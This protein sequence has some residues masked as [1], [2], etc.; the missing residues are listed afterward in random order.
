[1]LLMMSRKS[2]FIWLT[3]QKN[4]QKEYMQLHV[5][6]KFPDVKQKMDNC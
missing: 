2:L 5:K 4:T 3:A 1:M 6:A